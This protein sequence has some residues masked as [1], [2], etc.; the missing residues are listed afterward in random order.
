MPYR[1]LV[2]SSVSTFDDDEEA[3]ERQLIMAF[4]IS[5]IRIGDVN[6]K[7]CLSRIWQQLLIIIT[8]ILSVHEH[9]AEIVDYEGPRLS[10]CRDSIDR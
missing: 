10:K 3:S 1:T 9:G 5:S 7:F 4:V 8:F 6:E 2:F